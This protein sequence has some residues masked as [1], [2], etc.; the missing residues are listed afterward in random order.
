[1]NSRLQQPTPQIFHPAMRIKPESLSG[2]LKQKLPDILL[3]SGDDPF[4]T[5]ESCDQ[6]RKAC[7]ESGFTERLS[8]QASKGFDWKQLEEPMQSLSLFGSKRLIELHWQQLPE[9]PGKKLLAAWAEQPPEDCCLLITTDRLPTSV[10]NSKWFKV[11][12]NHCLHVQIWPLTLSE[13]PNWINQRLRMKGFLPTAGAVKVL[14]ENVEGNL[15]A[16]SQEIEKLR[17][18]VDGKELDETTVLRCVANSSHYSV[19]E[20]MEEVI[21]GNARHAIHILNSLQTEGV[22]PSIILWAVTKEVRLLARIKRSGGQ[23]ADVQSLLGKQNVP[24]KR[25]ASYEKHAKMLRPLLLQ[26][27]HQSCLKT[28]LSI[29]GAIKDNPWS[30]LID[31]C[32]ALAGHMPP[33][34]GL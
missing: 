18:L 12:E 17:L 19:F 3:V 25:W 13:L 30:H 27:A 29:K 11:I 14:C 1:M 2:H 32:L 28:E 10:L 6:L 8:L 34:S 16:A 23:P 21:Q 20:L 33:P 7:K 22:A 4:L 5:Q 24:R 31:G 26:K 9:E 15:L